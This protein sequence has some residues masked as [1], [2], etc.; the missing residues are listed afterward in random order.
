MFS[1][2]HGIW[3]SQLGDSSSLAGGEDDPHRPEEGSGAGLEDLPRGGGTQQD[4]GVLLRYPFR[5]VGLKEPYRKPPILGSPFLTQ[6][7]M[8]LSH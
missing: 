7:H 1:E 3:E 8:G 2:T 6:S 5:W 4:P